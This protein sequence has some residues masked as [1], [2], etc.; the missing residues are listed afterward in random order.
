[1]ARAIPQ[2]VSIEIQ[3][4]TAAE[5]DRCDVAFCGSDGTADRGLALTLPAGRVGAWELTVTVRETV[6]AG[7]GYLFQ[8]HGFSARAPCAGLQPAGAR[9]RHP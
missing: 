7:G 6:Q 1:M 3:P 5:P 4:V 2:R 9:L 8:R